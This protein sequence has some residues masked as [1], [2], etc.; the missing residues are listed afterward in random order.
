MITYHIVFDNDHESQTRDYNEISRIV[1]SKPNVG[2]H[3]VGVYVTGTPVTLNPSNP[4]NMDKARLLH[5]KLEK[6][7]LKEDF[8]ERYD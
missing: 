7:V 1:G 2:A 6:E 3:F 5:Q 4:H 8:A